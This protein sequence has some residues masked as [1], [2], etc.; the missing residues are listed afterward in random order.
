MLNRWDRL[1]V[2]AL[3]LF[4]VAGTVGACTAAQQRQ[5]AQVT[6]YAGIAADVLELVDRHCA[7]EDKPRACLQKCLDALGEGAGGGA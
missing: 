7:P 6:N 5:L 3:A 4:T 1:T 2:I